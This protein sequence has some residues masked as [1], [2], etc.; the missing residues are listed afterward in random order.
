MRAPYVQQ[1]GEGC[2]RKCPLLYCT[3][4]HYSR[5]N[6]R[7]QG[8]P[9]RCTTRSRFRRRRPLQ[10]CGTPSQPSPATGEDCGTRRRAAAPAGGRGG[11]PGG[12]WLWRSSLYWRR[13]D[14]W[15]A[16][17]SRVQMAI[18][19]SAWGAEPGRLPLARAPH[20]NLPP[21]RGKGLT[22]LRR[23][24]RAKEHGASHESASP[25]WVV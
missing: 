5:K 14:R 20:P 13:V 17:E 16:G 6:R 21:R 9:S 2:D 25:C 10:S 4:V 22:A 11:A 3:Y 12:G 15:G 8:Q 24:S 18:H 19:T 23:H 1:R 7:G